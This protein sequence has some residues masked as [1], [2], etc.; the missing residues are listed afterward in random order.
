MLTYPFWN[1]IAANDGI[2][3]QCPAVSDNG[4]VHSETHT[5]SF[6]LQNQWL[7]SIYVKN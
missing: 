4:G 3:L 6:Y 1:F 5:R 7:K 2:I